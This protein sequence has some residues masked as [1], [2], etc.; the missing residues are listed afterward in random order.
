MF[1][2]IAYLII[3][4]LGTLYLIFVLGRFLLQLARADFYN[5]VSQSI[6]KFTS[7]LLN[8]L[9]KIIPGFG[10]VDIACLVLAALINFLITVVLFVLA[11][12]SQ[13][14]L[15]NLFAWSLLGTFA[16]LVNIVFWAV[17]IVIILSW[18]SMA[19][20]INN[21]IAFLLQQMTEPFMRPFRRIMPDTGGLDFSPILLLLSIH[22]IEVVIRHAGD[23]IGVTNTVR[24]LVLGL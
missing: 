14:P 9:R 22:V 11:G 6:V 21:P 24:Q 19:T 20:Q 2:E 18:L 13:L 12:A 3:T 5:P 23:A 10:G 16:F 1:F 17:L 7:P 15:G 4:T 8:P